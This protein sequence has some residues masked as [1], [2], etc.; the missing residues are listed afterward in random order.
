MEDFIKQWGP[1]IITV[2]AF[3]ILIGIVTV[4]RDPIGQAFNDLFTT[5]TKSVPAVTPTPS[6][7]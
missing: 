5:F 1:A 3:M 4:F 2:I 7:T 6:I